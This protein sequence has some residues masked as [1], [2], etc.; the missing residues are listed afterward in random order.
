[1]K[2]IFLAFFAMSSG[3]VGMNIAVEMKANPKPQN[4]VSIK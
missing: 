2:Q 4:P 3:P 1:V